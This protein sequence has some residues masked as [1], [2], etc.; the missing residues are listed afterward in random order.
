[1]LDIGSNRYVP[2]LWKDL[3]PQHGLEA[4]DIKR[5]GFG[6]VCWY[7]RHSLGDKTPQELA[8]VDVPFIG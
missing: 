5:Q 6:G 1:M 2:E 3:F 7:E 8:P 4:E